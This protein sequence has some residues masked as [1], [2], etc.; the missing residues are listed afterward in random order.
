MQGATAL[1]DAAANLPIV[2]GVRGYFVRSNVPVA[3]SFNSSSK[4]YNAV[5]DIVQ[6]TMLS[7]LVSIHTDCPTYE[8]LGWQ[9][10][11]SD[12]AP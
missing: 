7:N 3:G 8:K 12:L 6:R 2:L 5:Y 10:V 9:E 1:A 11:V 4:E